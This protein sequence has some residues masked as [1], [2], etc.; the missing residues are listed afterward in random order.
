MREGVRMEV[1]GWGRGT[2]GGAFVPDKV[3][4]SVEDKGKLIKV[5]G[6]G[7]WCN[8]SE[9]WGWKHGNWGIS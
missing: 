8:G 2:G 1:E 4:E 9:R 7:R 5:C 3:T 6:E